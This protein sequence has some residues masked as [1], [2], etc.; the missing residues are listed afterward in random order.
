[1]MMVDDSRRGLARPDALLTLAAVLV[2]GLAAG[3]LVSPALFVTTTLV[4]VM[5]WRGTREPSA[6]LS[7]DPHS[8]DLAYLPGDLSSRAR[9]ALARCG[10]GD[11]HRLLLAV[12]VQARPLF[13]RD[14][15][16]LDERAERETLEN[17]SSLV[18]ACCG[19]A[20]SLAELDRTFGASS[21]N[22]DVAAR[23]AQMRQRLV[24]Q[25][26]GAATSLSNL[27]LAGLEKET[28]ALSHVSE[29]TTAIQ[30]DAAVRQTATEELRRLL[31]R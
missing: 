14:R 30:E 29:L 17:V 3:Q 16:Q 4:A 25:L 2:S 31:P 8:D 1:M 6:R 7:G 22:A 21:Q 10:E 26:S 20:E 15:A 24:E 28:D 5:V 12:V 13:A 11:G 9:E 23:F 27:Y 18:E 19:T